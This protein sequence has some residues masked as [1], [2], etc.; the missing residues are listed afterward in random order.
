M[1]D[2]QTNSPRFYPWVFGAYASFVLAILAVLV[3]AGW[4]V[5]VDFEETRKGLLQAEINR[6][7]SHAH[8]TVLRLQ[9]NL[10]A[11]TPTALR[12]AISQDSWLREHWQTFV[13]IDPSRLYAAVIA[14]DGTI[15]MHS[16]PEY[17]G[18][19]LAPGWNLR[20]ID[21]VGE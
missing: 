13:P 17:E 15:I 2:S 9:T 4:G 12:D 1:P 3:I 7:R 19:R 5:Y 11:D 8:P 20:I 6:L 21:G 16:V 10:P 14:N 18:K